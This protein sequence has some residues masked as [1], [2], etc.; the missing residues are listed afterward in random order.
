MGTLLAIGGVV[1]II[2]SVVCWFMILINAFQDEVWKGLLFFFC[3]LYALYYAIVEF[4]HENKW[5]IVLGNLV[6]GA[7]GGILVSAG[8]SMMHK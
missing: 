5:Q 6:G 3:G 4:D 2:A 7:I 8:I 1:C